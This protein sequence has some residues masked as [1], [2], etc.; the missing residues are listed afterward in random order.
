MFCLIETEA[1]RMD[2]HPPIEVLNAYPTDCRPVRVEFLGNAG[3]FSGARFWKLFTPVGEFCL[4]Q[5]PREFPD[6]QRLRFLH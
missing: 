2:E 6:S 1:P 4:R 5:W 3:G